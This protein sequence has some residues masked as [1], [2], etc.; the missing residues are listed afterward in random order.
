MGLKD[1]GW[2][3]EPASYPFRA[4]LQTRYGDMDANAHLNNVAIAR[5]FEEARLR[6]HMAVRAEASAIDPSGVMI[7]HI[8][9]DYLAEGSYPAEVEAGVGVEAIGTRSYRL[10]IG[11]FQEGRAMA[12]ATCVMVHR[13]G[14]GEAMRAA[15]GA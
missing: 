10:A 14:I 3:C 15:L 2:R 4:R 5:L 6:F 11:L 7:A 8:A 9:I 13:D 12:L 1:E